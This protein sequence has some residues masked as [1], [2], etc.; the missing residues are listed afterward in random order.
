MRNFSGVFMSIAVKVFNRVILNR[1]YDHS[2]LGLEEAKVALSKY[3][4][5]DEYLNNTDRFTLS[6][7]VA[8]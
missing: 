6:A 1:I 4:L 3:V 7:Y 8:W 5:P 2:K